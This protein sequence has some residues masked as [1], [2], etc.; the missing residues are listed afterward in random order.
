MII[1]REIKK[2]DENL[3]ILITQLKTASWKQKAPIW[4]DIA[5]RLEKSNKNWAQVNVSHLTK[6]AKKNETIIIPGKLLG[7]GYI[8]IPVTIAAYQSTMNAKEKITD[9]GG[10]VL[11]IDELLKKNPK[12]TGI[13]IFSK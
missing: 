8:D 1:M 4:R 10:K 2:S 5:R 11:T 3:N 9:A 12:G 13:R 7:A 6:Y